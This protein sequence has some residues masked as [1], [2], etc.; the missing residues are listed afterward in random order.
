MS[1][2]EGLL[3]GPHGDIILDLLF[4]FATWHAYAKH[5][6]HT[7]QT[8]KFFDE[9]TIYLGQSVWKFQGITSKDY[10]TTELPQEHVARV[11]HTATVAARD[12]HLVSVP[13]Q[14]LNRRIWT[15]RHTIFM[16]SGVIQ[17]QYI[18]IAQLT[19]IPHR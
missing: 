2:F 12:G 15:C 18:A 10:F 3:P 16:P 1:I 9:A 6:L 19:T 13:D 7:D 11:Q 4:D 8:L 14:K 5:R 17:T